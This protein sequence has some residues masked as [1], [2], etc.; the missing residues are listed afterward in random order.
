MQDGLILMRAA[1]LR[2]LRLRRALPSLV[3]P[4]PSSS[5]DSDIIGSADSDIIRWYG[6]GLGLKIKRL[7][8]GVL[9]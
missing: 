8:R 9:N 6:W 2:R 3:R 7:C 5:A 4:L 1:R